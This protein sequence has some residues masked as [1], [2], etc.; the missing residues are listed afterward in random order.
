MQAEHC[1]IVAARKLPSS[2]LVQVPRQPS[3]APVLVIGDARKIGRKG[4]Q[5]LRQYG[6]RS[7]PLFDLHFFAPLQCWN[8]CTWLAGNCD[9]PG[10]SLGTIGSCRGTGRDFISTQDECDYA[11][12]I[13]GLSDVGASAV[14]YPT[15]PCVSARFDCCGGPV[16]LPTTGAAGSMQWLNQ[17]THSAGDLQA[18]L[19]L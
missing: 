5:G 1:G 10:Y 16:Y 12:A 11:A 15:N 2:T 3:P 7:L 13:L 6:G 14:D 19:L 17:P 4:G 9:D 8:V 18:R